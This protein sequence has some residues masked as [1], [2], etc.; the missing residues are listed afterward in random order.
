[1]AYMNQERKAKV[2]QQIK[3]ILNKHGLKGTL[4]VRDHITLVLTVQSGAIDF[5]SNYNETVGDRY[6]CQACVDGY[7]N[8]NQ[9]HYDRHFSGAAKA[10]LDEAV[11]MLN[12]D[13]YDHSDS[14]TDYFD[15]GHFVDICIGRWNK[16]YKL[17][18]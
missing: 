3:A 7:I 14:Q 15:V 4:S 18:A 13:N 5:S 9:Y 1:M 16:P 10:F 12:T 8:V 6:G 17:V 11:A 2:A